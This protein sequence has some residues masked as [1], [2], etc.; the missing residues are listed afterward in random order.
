LAPR[1]SGVNEFEKE[2]LRRSL[3][4]ANAASETPQSFKDG[5][6]A[7][8]SPSLDDYLQQQMGGDNDS[9]S[10]LFGDAQKLFSDFNEVPKVE[11]MRKIVKR[12][13]RGSGGSSKTDKNMSIKVPPLAASKSMAFTPPSAQEAAETKSPST[14]REQMEELVRMHQLKINAA[15]NKARGL[16]ADTF[17][18]PTLEGA[19]LT[20]GPLT[21]KRF[22]EGGE[23]KKSEPSLFGVSD[24]ATK[25]S[26]EM[27]PD[28]LG[29]DDQ[30]DA[31]RH[32]L[33]AA[34]VSRKYGPKA[35][36]LLGKAHE[37]TSNPQTFF[38]LFG[39]GQP[40]DDLPYD[41]HNNRIGAELGSRATSQAELEKLV[42]AMALQAQTKQTRDKP[43]IMSR[44]QMQARKEKAEKGMTERPQGYQ[45]GGM[46]KALKGTKAVDK[47]GRPLTAYRGE[48]G[49]SDRL[50]TELG[51]Y[52]FGT[53]DA[54]NLYAT[55]PNNF[56]NVAEA[57]K[58]FPAQLSI[59]KPV[60]NA[61]GDSY[62]DLPA[63][64]KALGKK[65]FDRVV[66]KNAGNIEDT[67]AFEDLADAKGY[68]SVLDL[69]RKNPKD[70]DSL[71]TQ[72]YPILDDPKSVKVLQ[73][74][75]YDGAI[76]GGSG[77]TGGE[78]EYRVFS[79]SQAISPYGNKPMAPR[80]ARQQVGDFLQS[81]D[82][83]PTD[84]LGFF[85][86]AA[87][88]AGT[89]LTPST[90]NEGEE[91]ELARRRA[92]PSTISRPKSENKPRR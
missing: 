60:V 91:A 18:A 62:I 48:Y 41:V 46:V 47:E 43:Y 36:E 6:Q 8:S 61:P 56:S 10:A 17:G 5:G 30:R 11:P 71:Y 86:K 55:E 85:G 13:S 28:Q 34:T 88:A 14:A 76:Y 44:E 72:L 58:V 84:A 54:A 29:Q 74:R 68:T 1:S 87:S 73:K 12:V 59:R 92:M 70:L 27:F 64:R 39:I 4:N 83:S 81:M 51:S 79:A 9:S 75:G 22:A 67:Q 66:Q 2:V 50:S 3:G 42:Q 49:P 63:L 21:K 31:A 24:Y 33:A 89:A 25:A 82:M 40:R 32:M 65:E 19:T 23:A 45:K 7:V 37:Y 90:L 57:M 52:S 78:A 35:A 69:M 20:K 53:K 38:S 77:A 15:R 16:S 26:A 80:S